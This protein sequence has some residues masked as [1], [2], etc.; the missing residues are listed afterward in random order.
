MMLIN[1]EL[2][3]TKN[4]EMR[5]GLPAQ[6]VQMGAGSSTAQTQVAFFIPSFLSDAHSH[7]K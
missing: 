1:G 3:H 4:A 7:K 5:R 2:I 6:L